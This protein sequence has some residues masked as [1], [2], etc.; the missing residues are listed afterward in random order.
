MLEAIP[1]SDRFSSSRKWRRLPNIMSRRTIRLQ[2]SPSTSR[3]RLIG[4]PDRISTTFTNLPPKNR[5]QYTTGE[6]NPQPVAYEKQIGADHVEGQRG[7]VHPF[8]RR[9]WPGERKSTRLNSS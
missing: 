3:V 6:P 2:R 8:D 9:L 7:C 1:S 4:H 5:L